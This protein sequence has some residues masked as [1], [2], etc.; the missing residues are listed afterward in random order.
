MRRTNSQTVGDLV[1]AFIRQE[2]LETPLNQ[3]RLMEAWKDVMG[4][5]VRKYTGDMFIS[6]QT[7]FVKILSAPLKQNLMMTRTVLVDRLN[8]AVDAQVITDIRFI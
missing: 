3:Y 2:G 7:L 4:E 6:N 5:T 8:K 1:R